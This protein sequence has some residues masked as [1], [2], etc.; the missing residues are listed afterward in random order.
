MLHPARYQVKVHKPD[1]KIKAIQE[2]TAPPQNTTEKANAPAFP[3][4]LPG[5]E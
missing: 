5:L 3:A 2:T 1:E 4:V